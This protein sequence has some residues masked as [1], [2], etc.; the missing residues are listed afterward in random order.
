MTLPSV[1]KFMRCTPF[2]PIRVTEAYSFL[3]SRYCSYGHAVG[4]LCQDIVLRSLKGK[5]ACLQD[6]HLNLVGKCTYTN[7][8]GGSLSQ[9]GR[10]YFLLHRNM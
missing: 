1:L 8:V 10:G 5:Q 9:I 4:V 3:H 2:A 6:G 7:I